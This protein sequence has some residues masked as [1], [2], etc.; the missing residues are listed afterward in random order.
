MEEERTQAISSPTNPPN[1]IG[2][3]R[4]RTTKEELEATETKPVI[5]PEEAEWKRRRGLTEPSKSC[6]QVCQIQTI[7]EPNHEGTCSIKDVGVDTIYTFT[8]P[9]EDE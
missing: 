5:S 6:P 2:Q 7:N 3:I 1:E 8:K 9:L 4:Y